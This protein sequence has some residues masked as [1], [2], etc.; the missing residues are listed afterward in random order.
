MNKDEIRKG[1]PVYLDTNPAQLGALT[2]K[3]MAFGDLV[4]VQVDWG[5]N[6]QFED[7]EHLCIKVV[8]EGTDN[9]FRSL[10]SPAHRSSR[11]VCWESSAKCRS[12]V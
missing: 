3:M 4:M 5:A 9:L 12:S 10:L 11:G 7:I 6:A 8:G 1:V 2:G